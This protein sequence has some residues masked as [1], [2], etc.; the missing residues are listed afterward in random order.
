MSSADLLRGNDD[1]KHKYFDGHSQS[2]YDDDHTPF[3]ERGVPILHL[4]PSPLP[5]V[6]HRLSD[7]ATNIDWDSSMDMLN[8]VNAFLYSVLHLM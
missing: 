6:W 2:S 8:M 5:E 7:N 1:G 4:I 3:M